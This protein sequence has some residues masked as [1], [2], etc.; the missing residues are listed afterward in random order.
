[1]GPIQGDLDS[2]CDYSWA[3]SAASLFESHLNIGADGKKTISISIQH[4]F[5]CDQNSGNKGC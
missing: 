3:L 4:I 1:M 2:T 5:D